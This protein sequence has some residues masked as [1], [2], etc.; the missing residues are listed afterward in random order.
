MTT[1]KAPT[2]KFTRSRYRWAMA[3]I[4]EAEAE[5]VAGW[6][7]DHSPTFTGWVL[8][9]GTEAPTAVSAATVEA[10]ADLEIRTGAAHTY[11]ELLRAK[12]ALHEIGPVGRVDEF[13]DNLA[14]TLNM[15]SFTAV[16]MA[17]NAVEI[18]I[19]PPLNSGNPHQID[20]AGPLGTADDTFDTQAAAFAAAIAPHITVAHTVVDGRG[21]TSHTAFLGGLATTTCTGGFAAS[22]LNRYGIITAGHCGNNQSIGDISLEF[23]RGYNGITADAQFHAIPT[24]AGHVLHDDIVC[25]N[26]IYRCDMSSK[27]TRNRMTNAYVCHTG[28]RSGFSCGTVSRID[29]SPEYPSNTRA[30]CLDEHLS[31][32]PCDDVFVRVAGT[33][34]KGCKGDSGGPWHQGGTAYGIHMGGKVNP[35]CNETG[36]YQFFSAIDEVERFLGVS[37]LINGDVA[38]S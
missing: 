34:L 27:Q 30:A 36:V 19:D 15:I 23:V 26:L 6:G 25:D 11:S 35:D 13:G 14:G 22:Y 10:N 8:L 12:Q 28:K 17:A 4:R 33:S 37:I 38:I 21:L 29:Y 31:R 7:I 32:S 16:D 20:D 5:R 2:R 3:A 9:T 24:G 18:G 1:N